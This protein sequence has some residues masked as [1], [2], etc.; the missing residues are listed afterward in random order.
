MKPIKSTPSFESDR[1]RQ[2]VTLIAI[3][4]A[5]A[6]NVLANIYPINGLSIGQVSN[7][8]FGDVKITPAN[9]AFAIW[10]LIYL[11]LFSLGIYQFLPAQQQNPRLKNIGY[12]IV[13]ASLAQIVWVY[14][15]LSRM[16]LF[17]LVAMLVILFSLI[18]A[19]LEL[20]REDINISRKE[21]WWVDTPIS[22][23]FGWISVATIVN[24]ATVLTHLNWNGWGI[25][26]EIWTVVM[27]IVAGFLASLIRIKFTETAYSLVFIWAIVAIGIRQINQPVIAGTAL[28]V[29][30][31]IAL[32]GVGS[33]L[34]K[35]SVKAR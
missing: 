35:R 21:I 4:A 8:L 15:F 17:S 7:Q 18:G 19:Y 33:T 27:L 34:T 16:F 3:F 1:L 22:I 26:A 29:A 6:V 10:G 25:S 31:V 28:G 20:H 11:G 14:V 9:Y 2:W 32:V 23:Y 30:L 13:L 12:L 5:F 24:V